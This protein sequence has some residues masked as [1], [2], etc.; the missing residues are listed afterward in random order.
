[1]EYINIIDNDKPNS[2]EETEIDTE[3]V[4]INYL[5]KFLIIP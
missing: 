1:M 3:N 4:E 2:E 5:E